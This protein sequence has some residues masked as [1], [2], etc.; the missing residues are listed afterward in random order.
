MKTIINSLVQTIERFLHSV[1]KYRIPIEKYPF[2][3]YFVLNF[4]AS[5]LRANDRFLLS[6][7]NVTSRKRSPFSR[8]GFVF[9][10]NEQQK[11]YLPQSLV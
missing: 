10:C 1:F 9:S 7:M 4:I 8:K 2:P 5:D 6:L 11:V 3:F